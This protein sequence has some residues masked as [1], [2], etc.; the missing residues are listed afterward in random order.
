T[1]SPSPPCALIF[2]R[3]SRRYAALVIP[4]IGASTTGVWTWTLPS[5]RPS[6]VVPVE[7]M[8]P[9]VRARR[10]CPKS[11]QSPRGLGQNRGGGTGRQVA[12][13]CRQVGRLFGAMRQG[14][15]EPEAR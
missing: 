11:E 5:V 8:R 3:H 4:A 7:A 13:L 1:N 10:A 12:E 6:R 2:S 14:R 15:A 9:I